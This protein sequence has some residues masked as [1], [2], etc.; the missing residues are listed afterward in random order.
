MNDS[1][2]RGQVA[3]VRSDAASIWLWRFVGANYA[4]DGNH[5]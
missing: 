4:M 1:Q 5:I 2:C 3:S